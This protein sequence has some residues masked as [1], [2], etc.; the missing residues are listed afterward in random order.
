MQNIF[1]LKEQ[2]VTDTPLLLFDCTLPDGHAEHWSTHTVTVDGVAYAP[3]VLQ[4]NVFELQASSDQGVDGVPRISLV[5]ANADS[6]CSEIER[7]TGWKGARLTA[8]LV[9]YDLREDAPVTERSV[10]FQGICNSPDEILEATLRLSATNRMNLQRLLLPQVRIQRRCPW[11]FPTNEG[12]RTEAID[13]GASGKYSRFYRCG[14]SAGAGGGSGALDGSVPYANC[15]YTRADCETRGMFVNFGGIEFVP[16]AIG[17]RTF[18]DKSWHTSA[19]SV[20]EAR[21]NDFVPMIYGTA[22]YNPPVVFARND[23]NL[24]RMEV[25]LGL[26]EMQGVLKVLVN[27]VEIPQG[28]NGTNMTG[29]GWF[30]IPTLGTRSGAFNPDF[31]DGAGHPTGDP[32]GSMAYLSVVVPNRINDGQTL[33]RVAVLAQGMKLPVYAADGLPGGEQFSSNPAW[34]LLDVLRRAGWSLTE[35]DLTSFASAAA[36]CDEGI[37]ALDLYG[38]AITLSRFQ[39]NLALQKRKSAGDVVRGVRNAAR[40]LLTYGANGALQCRVQNSMA[41][42][43]PVKPVW[44]NATETWNGGWPSY[45]FGDGSSAFTGIVRRANGEPTFRMYSRSMA[46]TPNRFSVEF[47]DALNEFQ[48]DSFSLVDADDV[49]RCGQEVSQTLAA[50]GLP[51]F[52]Q[53]ARI[54]KLN[55]DRSVRGNTYVEFET[56]VKAFGVRPGDLITITYLKEGLNREAFRVLKIAPGMNHRLSTITAQI[57]DDSW[58]AD[59]NGQLTSASGGRRQSS[60]GVGVPRPLTGSVLDDLGDIQFG[61]EESATT[62]GDGSVQTDLTVG[63]V[64]PAVVAASGVGIPL[65][66]LAT[67][68]GGG[69]VLAGGQALYY[70][71]AGVDASGSESLPSFIVRAITVSN[72][73]S[74]TIR[75]LSFSPGTAAFHVYRGTS[76]AVLFRIASNLPVAA[77][78]VDSGYAKELIAPM[79]QNFDHANFY[80]RME[81]QPEAAA[82]IHGAASIGNDGIDMTENRYRGMTARITRGA[83]AGQERSITSNTASTLSVAPG[84]AVVPDATSF[85]VVAE[86]GWQFGATTRSSPV[87]FEVSNRAGETVQICGRAANVNDMECAEELS[88]VTRHQ[89][90][91]SGGGDSAV[92]EVPYFGLG[93]GQRGGTVELSGVSF[94]SLDN[95]LTISAAT[96]TLHYWDE[97][98]ARPGALLANAISAADTAIDLSAASPAVAGSF[99]QV[100]AEVVRIDAVENGGS[101]WQVTRGMHLS[102]A[103]AHVSQSVPYQ[104]LSKS[105]IASFPPGFFGSPYSGS[106]SHPITLPNVRVASA[107]L[108]VTNRF[109]NSPTRSICL[110]TTVDHGLRTLSGGQY[111]IQV[112]GYLAVEQSAAPALIVEAAHAVGDVYAVLGTVADAEVRLQVNVEG[113]AYCAL[114]I[115]AG[116]TTSPAA[117]GKSLA[118]LTAGEKITLSILSVGQTYPGANLTVLIRI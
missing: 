115:P 42:E 66:S 43:M 91:G 17:V 106:W 107:D 9:F 74:V 36:Y 111:S 7:S 112:D 35:L 100:D 116:M 68:V 28:I 5:L 44:S 54:L 85:F 16:P 95:T 19:I 22:W 13:G 59:S 77:Q 82:T 46:D 92:P 61:V 65:L 40:L 70:A 55:L 118:P 98:V 78:F 20:N 30:N 53:A 76:P 72:G 6:H 11:E 99:V 24:T 86:P 29:T 113:A 50:T 80:W 58:Y 101:R 102:T 34:V 60:A 39:C 57:H 25:L 75:D 2:A 103:A 32:Y 104:L 52:D 15:G 12:Q 48:Q 79:D 81:L 71:V 114:A 31:K 67:T 10:L 47:Q 1:E 23:G 87:R 88:I 69:G 56:S 117:D 97:L 94:T 26:G 33:P 38:N 41:H 105:M 64:A 89:I 90:G 49:A 45:E 3:R 4:H 62:A 37:D 73:S 84:W 51:N 21:Y 27:D 110:T 96:L 14:Y 93:P 63:F 18:G 8:G 109:G 108:F 83:G